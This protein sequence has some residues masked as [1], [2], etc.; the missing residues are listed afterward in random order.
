M[1]PSLWFNIPG[2]FLSYLAAGLPVLA[3]I[4]RGTDFEHIINF[5]E[6]GFAYTGDSVEEFSKK[7]IK[8]LSEKNTLDKMAISGKAFF[9]KTY[10]VRR[11]VEQITGHL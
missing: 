5:E 3:R 1:S 9:L 4:N 6:L 10:S 2:K 7:T 8:L 11:T